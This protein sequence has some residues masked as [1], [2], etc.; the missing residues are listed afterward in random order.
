MLTKRQAQ[1]FRAVTNLEIVEALKMM[2]LVD[3]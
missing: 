3:F 2:A 1:D